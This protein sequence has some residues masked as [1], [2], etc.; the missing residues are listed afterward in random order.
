MLC[1][2][3]CMMY[4]CWL[5]HF[6]HVQVF[7]T[8]WTVACQDPLSMGFSRQEYWRGL[9]CPPPGNLPDPR[10]EAASRASCIGR[11]VLTTTVTSE[12]HDV[13]CS[14][15]IYLAFSYHR[16]TCPSLISECSPLPSLLVQQTPGCHCLKED[17]VW[18]LISNV[19]STPHTAYS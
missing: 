5:S 9:P 15:N 10:I 19:I 8:L 1:S 6:S 2:M 14:T 7:E 3:W 16:H 11:Q 13:R 17:P 18:P 4:V 12:A